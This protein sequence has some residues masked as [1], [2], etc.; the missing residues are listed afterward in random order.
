MSLP[1]SYYLL[2]GA[3]LFTIGVIGVLVRRNVLVLLMSIEL[4][5]NASNLTFI[6]FSKYRGDLHG[7]LFSFFS[8][9]VAAA[10]AAVGLAIVIHIFRH[11]RSTNVDEV[12]TIQG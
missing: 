3:A 4:I 10:E 5:L 1:I 8:I 12:T 11:F 2:L 7:H 6:A 9:A